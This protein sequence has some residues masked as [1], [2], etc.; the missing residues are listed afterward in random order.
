MQNSAKIDKQRECCTVAV[1]NNS[2]GS[3]QGED[4]ST[5]VT[6]HATRRRAVFTVCRI[7]ASFGRNT[8]VVAS[9]PQRSKYTSVKYMGAVS[10]GVKPR[11]PSNSA[12]PAV[13]TTC[14]IRPLLGKNSYE[15]ELRPIVKS[16]DPMKNNYKCLKKN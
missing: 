11:S 13:T 2:E 1:H 6:E 5:T 7:K 3:H 16:D 9:R 10:Q 4:E 12:L 15:Y 14:S 8:L